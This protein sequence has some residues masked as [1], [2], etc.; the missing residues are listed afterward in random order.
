[1]PALREVNYFTGKEEDH[2]FVRSIAQELR[3][4]RYRA[5]CGRPRRFHRP[6]AGWRWTPPGAVRLAV[7]LGVRV[8]VQPLHRTPR[9]EHDEERE[10]GRLLEGGD[11]GLRADRLDDRARGGRVAAPCA[12]DHDDLLNLTPLN[13]APRRGHRAPRQEHDEERERGRLLEVGNLGVR[14]DRLDDRAHGGRVAPRA[15]GTFSDGFSASR[16]TRRTL[17][18]RLHEPVRGA[19]P[20]SRYT[21]ASPTPI[22]V[23]AE[24]RV[25]AHVPKYDCPAPR[26]SRGTVRA[27]RDPRDRVGR[28][29]TRRARSARPSGRQRPEHASACRARTESHKQWF[30]D[31]E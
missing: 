15:R 19:V 14:A 23:R 13:N 31:S 5:G 21:G 16:A 3:S 22:G 10:R 7:R 25:A 12:R 28:V 30:I 2:V 27:V 26:G 6:T 17:R 29:R 20:R 4:R 8:P 1:M 24:P 11:L 9:Q 18:A